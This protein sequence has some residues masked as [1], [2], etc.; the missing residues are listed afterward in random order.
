MD[1][2]TTTRSSDPD[3]ARVVLGSGGTRAGSGPVAWKLEQ[4]T[5]RNR[6]GGFL[7]G[8]GHG[9]WRGRRAAV[10]R[11]DN[12]TC[13]SVL[14]V[15]RAWK[16]LVISIL[17]LSCPPAPSAQRPFQHRM[18]HHTKHPGSE[19]KSCVGP[20]R[21]GSLARHSSPS[22]RA[23]MLRSRPAPSAGA[24]PPWARASVVAPDR[25]APM[26]AFSGAVSI[27]WPEIIVALAEMRARGPKAWEHGNLRA[28]AWQVQERGAG[29]R[30]CKRCTESCDGGREVRHP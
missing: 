22:P 28:R 29:R 27:L 6:G 8:K 25:F 5:L 3:C 4:T 14:D 15:T 10:L 12:A 18:L 13:N 26:P 11:S 30:W 23:P 2:A 20:E 24:S 7:E 19:I 1:L 9:C 16:T 17:S 21:H